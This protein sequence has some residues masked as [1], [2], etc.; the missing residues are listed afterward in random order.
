MSTY[1]W[2][3]AWVP[4]RFNLF[5]RPNERA[6]AGYYSGQ[7]QVLDLLGESWVANLTLPPG[8][9]DSGTGAE[10]EAFF[11]RLRGRSNTIALWH[12][13]RPV[14]RGTLRGTPTISAPVAQLASTISISSG[15]AYATLSAGDLLG[16]GGQVSQVATPAVADASGVFAAVELA[17]RARTA[18]PAGTAV[19]WDKPTITF[20]L[21]DSDGVPVDWT[22]GGLFDG[23]A[24]SL[25]EA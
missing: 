18:I 12:L 17:V 24:I 13:K 14:P 20:R 8:I 16:F 25:V 4:T 7:S 19:Q 2:P 10:L 3:A 9:T 5:V 1:T 15:Q 11:N 23:P 6:F 21:A 22:A